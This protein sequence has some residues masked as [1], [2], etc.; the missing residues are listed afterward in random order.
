MMEHFGIEFTTIFCLID[1]A[2]SGKI[3][4]RVLTEDTDVFVLLVCW[5][6]REEMECKMQMERWDMTMLGNSVCRS[7]ASMHSPIAT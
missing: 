1:V 6:Y 7:M 3:M 2:N 4:I 5:M